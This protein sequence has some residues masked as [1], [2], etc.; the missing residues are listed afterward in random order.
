MTQ[1]KAPRRRRTPPPLDAARLQ[2]LALRYVGRFSTTRAK[3]ADYLQRKLRERGWS[4]ETSPDIGPIIDRFVEFG[5]VDDAA[6]AEMKTRSLVQQGYGKRRVD[7]ALFLAGVD[8]ADRR[9]SEA[10]LDSQRLDAAWRFAERK[11]LGPFATQPVTDRA[12]REKAIA[13]MLRAGHDMTIARKLL[14]LPPGA[15]RTA[16]DEVD[17]I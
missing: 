14:D 17:G 13:A 8:D 12:T 1:T 4:G 15:D 7:G 3:L 16:L 2:E 9:G 10:I 6:Y 11:R 5:Y